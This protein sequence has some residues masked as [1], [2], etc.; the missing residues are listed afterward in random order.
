M[1]IN[2]FVAI[3]IILLMIE[4]P[5]IVMIIKYIKSQHETKIKVALINDKIERLKL[6][7]TFDFEKINDLIDKYINES[8]KLYKI[9]NFEYK[10]Q[11]EIYLNEEK[12]NDMIKTMTKDVMKKITPA[13]FSLLQLS[14]NLNTENDLI[15]FLCE[16]IKI[17][18]LSYSLEVNV[19]VQ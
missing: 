11:D 12:M 2:V 16:K 3:V 5:T 19:E 15:E 6:Y 8:G 14:Y 10:Q 1:N 18:V 17:Y 7:S 13:V 4:I 9:N